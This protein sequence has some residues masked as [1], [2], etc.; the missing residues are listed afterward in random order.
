MAERGNLHSEYRHDRRN[1]H[2]RH[3]AGGAA[4]ERHPEPGAEHEEHA[5][6]QQPGAQDARLRN[7]GGRH[8]HLHRQD[9]HPDAQ[10]DERVQGGFLRVGERRPDGRRAGQPDQGGNRRQL[11]R[12]PGL[13]RPETYQGPGQSHGR[14]APPVAARA[15]RELPGPA[16]KRPRA[17]TAHFLH[18]TQVH[19]YRSGIP[20]AGQKSPLRERRAGN[21]A[22][23][24]LHR[25]DSGRPGTRRGHAP[26]H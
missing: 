20:P 21:R 2:R 8:R 5:R 24:L 14:G 17:G 4:H 15:G 26:R 10:P 25:P 18:G 9:G 1:R 7:H 3:G 19:G 22:G 23:S 12:F 13:R 16:G 11:H 6:Q